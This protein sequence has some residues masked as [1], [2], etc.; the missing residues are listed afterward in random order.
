V[1]ADRLALIAP[2]WGFRVLGQAL[3][4]PLARRRLGDPLDR[5]QTL[6]PLLGDLRQRSRRGA[7]LLGSDRVA[8]LPSPPPALDESHAVEDG[9]LL[10]DRLT[11]DRQLGGER[12]G[13]RLSTSQEIAEQPTAARVGDRRPE[14]VD[15]AAATTPT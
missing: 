3:A 15:V 5:R 12:G 13:G 6:V 2:R 14:L 10:G 8:H 9:E 1:A 4:A 7:E 11:C